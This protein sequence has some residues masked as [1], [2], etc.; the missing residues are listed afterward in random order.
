M[1]V[2]FHCAKLHTPGSHVFDI[3]AI[4]KNYEKLPERSLD[5]ICLTAIYIQVKSYDDVSAASFLGKGE[6]K[7]ERKEKKVSCCALGE[8][9]VSGSLNS[10]IA[11]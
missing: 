5:K 7:E 11:F 2:P 1:P 4:L 8:S 9:R 3:K 10:Q 6:K